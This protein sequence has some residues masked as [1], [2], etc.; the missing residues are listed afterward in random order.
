MVEQV[1]TELTD[2]R[3]RAVRARDAQERLLDQPPEAGH[4]ERQRGVAEQSRAMSQSL[5]NIRERIQRNRLQDERLGQ[6]LNESK[7]LTD[8]AARAAEQAAGRVSR[9]AQA[10]DPKSPEAQKQMAQARESQQQAQEQL[11]ELVKLLDQG[12]DAYELQQ[13]LVKLSKDQQALSRQTR[14]M[15]PRTLGRS[16]EQLDEAQRKE[17]DKLADEQR[18]LS[19]QAKRLVEKMRSTSA[20]ISR[21]SKKPEDQATAEALRRAASTATQQ[22]LDQKMQKASQQAGKNQLAQAQQQQQQAQEVLN[23]MLQQAGQAE[24]IRQRILHRQLMKLVEAIRELR[25]QQKAQLDRLVAAQVFAGLDDP[26]M[27][28]RRNTLAV[29]EQARQTD[30]KAAPVAELL[31]AAATQQAEAIEGLRAADISRPRV[32]MAERTALAKLNEALTRAQEL[33][34]EAN[35]QLN[36]A[37]RRKLVAAYKKAVE[38]QKAILDR[39][40]E[41]IDAEQADRDRR[42]RAD[43]MKVGNRQADLRTMIQELQ[44]QLDDTIVYR[45]VHEQIDSWTGDAA[46]RLRRG[47]ADERVA[48]NQQLVVGSLEALIEALQPD[49][50]GEQF[51]QGAGGGGGGGQSGG[52]G[53]SPLV[54]PMAE[55]KLLRA[56]QAQVHALTRR[57]GQQD[58]EQESMLDA[59]TEQQRSLSETGEQLV[60][61]LQRQQQQRQ[62]PRVE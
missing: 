49:Q 61:S 17:L 45:S 31:E 57:I 21:Q 32:E 47:Q 58:G 14:K 41:L 36:N 52:A 62:Q 44:G 46:D 11:D 12:R 60:E 56:R 51:A 27:T 1:R 7:Q 13:K 26:L 19:E 28:L 10:D 9:A 38:E 5:R 23:Q 8:A 2:L 22:S 30:K 37:Q 15:L 35:Q 55:L 25:D 18:K 42:W 4:A 53:N 24:R 59:L 50:P 29:S 20:A 33:A 3:Q 40:R 34:A 43:A 6:T 48:F 54:P 16:R 39:T